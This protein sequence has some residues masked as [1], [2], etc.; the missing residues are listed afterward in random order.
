MARDPKQ[1][2]KNA[3]RVSKHGTSD[4]PRGEDAIDVYIPYETSS[5]PQERMHII[6]HDDTMHY[7]SYRYLMDIIHTKDGNGIVL[8]YS[9][10]MVKVT[11]QHLDEL[12]DHIAQGDVTFIQKFNPRRWE[13]PEENQPM[14]ESIDIVARSDSEGLTLDKDK[15]SRPTSDRN[16][17]P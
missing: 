10:L 16:E 13:R 6:R 9:F 12:I 8:V 14:I 2:L 4:D 3:R 7:P 15:K 5:H 1:V 17:Y 11:G